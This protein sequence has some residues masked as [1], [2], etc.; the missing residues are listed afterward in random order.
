MMEELFRELINCAYN[1]ETP[2]FII[3]KHLIN[4]PNIDTSAVAGDFINYYKNSVIPFTSYT[5]LEELNEHIAYITHYRSIYE[6]VEEY[7]KLIAYFNDWKGY[8]S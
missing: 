1:N 6:K 7:A 2:Q 4:V 5:C 8:W 3:V